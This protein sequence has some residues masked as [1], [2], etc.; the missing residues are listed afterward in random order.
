M[1]SRS[2][3]TALKG[4]GRPQQHCWRFSSTTTASTATPPPPPQV[5]DFQAAPFSPILLKARIAKH[6]HHPEE[7]T[8]TT[9]T[10]TAESNESTDP[11]ST[12]TPESTLSALLACISPHLTASSGADQLNHQQPL[13]DTETKA[14]R[15]ELIGEVL[16]YPAVCK[17][18]T[19]DTV[20]Q[21]LLENVNASST[22]SSTE[23][24]A[25]T[26]AAIKVLQAY[27]ST[28]SKGHRNFVPLAI[29]LIPFRHAVYNGHLDEAFTILDLTAAAPGYLRHVKRLWWKYGRRWALGTGSTL[30][31]VHFL[32]KSGL[33]GVWPSTLGVL[34]MV[35]AYIGNMTVLSGLAFAG[36]VSGSGE[37][38]KWLPGTPTTYWYS[39]AQEMKMASLIAAVDRA[40]PENQDECSFRVRKLLEARK[41]VS[42]EY[43]QETLMK[44][45]WARGGEGFEWTE[46]DQDPAEI[47]WRR[48]MERSKPARIAAAA[49]HGDKYKYADDLLPKNSL[50]HASLIDHPTAPELAP[51]GAN[52]NR[53]S[54]PG[55]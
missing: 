14:L 55:N 4:L 8:T 45:Y 19:R 1:L 3:R 21:F 38:L 6:L 5:I 9:T 25:A 11:I 49:A 18:L 35:S 48:K 7:S 46:P 32:L 44:E 50:P 23:D 37:V 24:S 2:A 42:I 52:G 20:Q 39:H 43:E 10:T 29:G 27:G 22:S 13:S 40:L 16:K 15:L 26:L 36:R 30:G 12:L 34:A 28:Y 31:A 51:D 33:V 41:M 54:L 53:S 47:L 17:T